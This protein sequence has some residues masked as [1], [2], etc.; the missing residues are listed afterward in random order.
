[1]KIKNIFE[2]EY[3]IDLIFKLFYS[4]KMLSKFTKY[5]RDI[6]TILNIRKIDRYLSP[7]FPINMYRSALHCYDDEDYDK[8]HNKGILGGNVY[9][10]PCRNFLNSKN[11]AA[12]IYFRVMNNY[13]H[14][15]YPRIN[16]KSLAKYYYS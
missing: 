8:I 1:M 5:T 2:S 16:R 14:P 4:L 10:F 9:K 13:I 3:N 11:Y 15:I 7:R 6:F 12:I